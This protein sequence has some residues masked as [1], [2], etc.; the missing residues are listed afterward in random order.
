ML[1]FL[2]NIS[3][4]VPLYFLYTCLFRIIGQKKGILGSLHDLA[5]IEEL[6]AADLVTDEDDSDE[7]GN[8]DDDNAIDFGSDAS[9]ITDSPI[10]Q[11]LDNKQEVDTKLRAVHY[12]P[13]W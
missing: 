11:T 6:N 7:D 12:S 10:L 3:K 9:F 8:D 2:V 13:K 4:L 5:N 1:C